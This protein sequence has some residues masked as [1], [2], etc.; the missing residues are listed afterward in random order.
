MRMIASATLKLLRLL[1][2]SHTYFR[3]F[4]KSRVSVY[5]INNLLIAKFTNVYQRTA[6]MQKLT[7][8]SENDIHQQGESY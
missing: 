8:F 4:K 2:A 1:S 5:I 7:A 6:G 3:C